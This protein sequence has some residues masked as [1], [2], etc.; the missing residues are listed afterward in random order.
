MRYSRII[1][2]YGAVE[3]R[4][5][6]MRLPISWNITCY[7]VLKGHGTHEG[8]SKIKWR[9]REQPKFCVRDPSGDKK[10]SE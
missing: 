6:L 5:I 3:Q 8:A 7:M 10:K 9:G 2:L 4:L 1:T